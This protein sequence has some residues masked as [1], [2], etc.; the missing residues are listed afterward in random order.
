MRAVKRLIAALEQP[1]IRQ[2]LDE[3]ERKE[4]AWGDRTS[5]R[6]LNE[7]E[8]ARRAAKTTLYRA[9]GPNPTPEEWGEYRQMLAVEWIRHG[10]N[11]SAAKV[12]MEIW[13]ENEN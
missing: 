13:A 2:L 3:A 6:A 8:N 7:L 9:P 10:L 11:K 4:R 12:Y 5:I 1:R